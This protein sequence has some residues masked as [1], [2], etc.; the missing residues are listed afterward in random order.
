MNETKNFNFPV[1]GFLGILIILFAELGLIF[2]ISFVESFMTPICW[3]G[4]ILFLD[5]LNFKLKGNSLIKTRL[6]RFLIM[7]PVSIILWYIFELY[8]LFINNWHYINLPQNIIIRHIGYF[9][10]FA[11]IWPGVIEIY[12]LIRNSELFS[13]IKLKPKK[14]SKNF[15]IFSYI[16]GVICLVIPFLV[17]TNIAK[18]LA[19]PVWLGFIFL[20]EPLNYKLKLKSILRDFERGNLSRIMQLFF[21]GLIAGLL[22]EFWN[23]W[24]TTKWIYTVPILGHIKIFEMPVLGYLGFLTFAIEVFVMWQT[25]KYLFGLKNKKT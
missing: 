17:P 1:Y 14:I 22:W 23:F 9:W 8:N 13:N 3:T 18:Y 10:S 25:V 15:L 16:I 6:K 24:A 4:L 12:E 2:E 11:T 20:L 21:T 19:A 7:L 5:A